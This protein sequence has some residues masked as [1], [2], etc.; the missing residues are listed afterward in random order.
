MRGIVAGLAGMKLFRGMTQSQLVIN[1]SLFFNICLLVIKIVTSVSTGSLSIVSSVIDSAL[2]LFSSTVMFLVARYMR[3][4]HRH[5]PVGKTRYEPLAAI[6]IA[7]IMA[8]AAVEVIILSVEDALTLSSGPD[9][10][11]VALLL[12]AIV[13]ITKL[14]LYFICR[15]VPTPAAKAL[16]VDHINDVW[17]NSVAI[18]GAAL[19]AY[20][21]PYS[22]PIGAILISIYIIIT[23]FR[24]G[25]VQARSIAGEVAHGPIYNLVTWVAAMHRPEVSAVDTVRVYSLGMHYFAEVDLVLP[26]SMPLERAHN[27]G[28]AVQYTLERI[29]GIERAFVHLDIDSH[30][31]LDE[32]RDVYRRFSTQASADFADYLL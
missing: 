27:I 24:A 12:M 7:C 30:H 23:W 17:S 22:D 15:V 18:L 16:A 25:L 2:D 19:G 32:H 11:V 31:V 28:V 6:F 14:F 26:R 3:R 4:R 20:V 1:I 9:A 5:F 21:W 29:E 10:G 13:I 8:T